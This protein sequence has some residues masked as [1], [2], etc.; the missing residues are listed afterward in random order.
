MISKKYFKVLR[1]HSLG[2]EGSA[3]SKAYRVQNDLEGV[4]NFTYGEV[5]FL[6]FYALLEIVEPKAGE[7]FWDLGC[8]TGKPSIIAGLCYPELK[9]VKGVEF[10]D[11]LAEIAK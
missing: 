4:A 2:V 5:E 11:N 3:A 7:V 9:R 6:Y 8:G 10:C 1:Y